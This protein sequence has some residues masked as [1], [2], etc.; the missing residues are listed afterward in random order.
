ME[1]IQHII[2]LFGEE[3]VAIDNITETAIASSTVLVEV[4][5][6]IDHSTVENY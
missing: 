1:V 5:N 4:E 3:K 2:I 6:P